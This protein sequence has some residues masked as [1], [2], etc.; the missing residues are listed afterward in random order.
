MKVK[1]IFK[2]EQNQEKCFQI[3]GKI[4]AEVLYLGKILKQ[5]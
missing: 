5:H 2:K 1:Y 4:Q 3:I